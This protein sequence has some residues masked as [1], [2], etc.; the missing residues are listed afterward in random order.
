M[1]ITVSKGKLPFAFWKNAF[2]NR[3]D[4]WEWGIF[5][6]E[7]FHH[8]NSIWNWDL[9]P[10][11]F[12][13]CS[14]ITVGDFLNEKMFLHE[15][16]SIK[17]CKTVWTNCVFIVQVKFSTQIFLAILLHVSG[18]HCTSIDNWHERESTQMISGSLVSSRHVIICFGQSGVVHWYSAIRV[19]F[20]NQIP[21]R[22]GC[23]KLVK[24]HFDYSYPKSRTNQSLPC[25]G[26]SK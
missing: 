5:W 19:P 14:W 15:W 22:S 6:R 11:K 10:Y 26:K 4:K 12:P 20:V 17:N 9:F 16:I 18:A 1:E 7:S 13:L 23:N 24:I 3:N 2:G 8:P 21:R 25:Q